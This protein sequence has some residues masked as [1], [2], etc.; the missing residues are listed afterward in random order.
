MEHLSFKLL[1]LS[2]ITLIFSPLLVCWCKSL[3]STW[4]LYLFQLVLDMEYIVSTQLLSDV[5]DD[6]YISLICNWW[7]QGSFP[8]N[9]I[10]HLLP[11]VLDDILFSAISSYFQFIPFHLYIVILLILTACRLYFEYF[12]IPIFQKSYP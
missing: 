10:I 6:T 1:V 9:Y 8:D 12:R 2:S 7:H 5:L 4:K 11:G 3:P